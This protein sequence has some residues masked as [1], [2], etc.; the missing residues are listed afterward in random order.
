M[1]VGDLVKIKGKQEI[2]EVIHKSGAYF[3]L[4][5]KPKKHCCNYFLKHEL[6]VVKY[7]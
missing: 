6:K 2:H 4:D 1:K 7:A 3:I 5:P